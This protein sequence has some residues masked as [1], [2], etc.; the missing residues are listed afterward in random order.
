MTRAEKR[1]ARAREKQIR[2]IALNEAG[3]SVKEIAKAFGVSE[4]V[5]KNLLKGE[6]N[7]QREENDS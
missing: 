5:I 2:V 3:Y 6:K 7:E 4:S 1:E